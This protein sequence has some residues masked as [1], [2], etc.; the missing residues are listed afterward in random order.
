[1][2]I[3]AVRPVR[4]HQILRRDVKAHVALHVRKQNA[5]LFGLAIAVLE[6]VPQLVIAIAFVPA[7][8]AI[9]LA[10]ATPPEHF[11]QAPTVP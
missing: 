2:S 4:R 5:S 7:L 9:D 11:F 6:D 3:E 1:M 10:A 8:V